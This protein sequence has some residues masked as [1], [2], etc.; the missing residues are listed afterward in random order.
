MTST[1]FNNLGELYVWARTGAGLTVIAVIV[2]VI[3]VVGS[4]GGRDRKPRHGAG[5]GLLIILGLIICGY[6][7]WKTHR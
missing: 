7:W 2:I 1:G 4:G 6:L 5:N 3:L